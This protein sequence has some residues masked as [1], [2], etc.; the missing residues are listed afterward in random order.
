MEGR[1]IQDLTED[2]STGGKE[3]IGKTVQRNCDRSKK[4]KRKAVRREVGKGKDIQKQ[5]RFCSE[6]SGTASFSGEAIQGVRN[7]LYC[8]SLA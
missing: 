2:C 7:N 5:L 3:G 8:R 1:K 6:L 4:R